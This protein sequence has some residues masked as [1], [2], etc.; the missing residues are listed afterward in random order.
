M[1]RVV[2]ALKLDPGVSSKVLRLAN[3]AWLGLPH[4]VSS[5]HNAVALLGL[6]RIHALVLSGAA[7]V[8]T[9]DKNDT[10]IEMGRF[11]EHSVVVGMI[12]ESIGRH[13]QRYEPVDTGTLFTAGLLHDIGKL[14]LLALAP[15]R[16]GPLVERMRGEA[17]PFS[18]IDRELS[19]GLLGGMV[20]RHWSFPLELAAA[21]ECH[22]QP[23]LPEYF[24]KTVAITHLSDVMAHY[25]GSLTWADEPA[26]ELEDAALDR[27][28]LPPERLKVIAYEVLE[29]R[30]ALEALV[31]AMPRQ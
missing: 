22:H 12:A 26:P 9:A 1:V 29:N 14:T 10:F 7:G 27:I 8:L 19:H 4:R 3:S 16:L 18:Q 2:E 23:R 25:I 24:Q 31:E 15:H 21:I 6:Q 20:A 30:P 5:L 28:P 17:R 11:W 13:L